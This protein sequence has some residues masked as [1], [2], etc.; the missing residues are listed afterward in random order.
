MATPF[1][2][3]D[4]NAA[5]G[6][7]LETYSNAWVRS[8]STPNGAID[9]AGSAARQQNV[10]TAIYA[11]SN[12]LAPSADYEVSANLVVVSGGGT[13][14]VGIC[15]RMAGTGGAAVT[16][17]QARL[18]NNSSGLVL[19]RFING[20]TITLLS[21]PLN[22]EAGAS[23]KITLRMLGDQLSVLLD[24]V[25]VLGPVTDGNIT[26]P[27]YTGMR[28][29]SANTSQI[30]IDNL[31]S[32]PVEIAQPVQITGS[33]T[34]QSDSI[35]AVVSSEI[36]V[37]AA[38]NEQPESKAIVAVSQVR[39][40]LSWTENNESIYASLSVGDA[41]QD[42]SISAAWTEK[43]DQINASTTVSVS[44]SASWLEQGEVDA[45]LLRVGTAGLASI[46]WSEGSEVLR[47]LAS[48]QGE[49]PEDIDALTVPP[50]Q[51]VVFEGSSRVVAFEGG[52]RVVS[53]EGSKR[54]VEFQ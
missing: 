53:F 4:F 13:P 40:T 10:N 9:V 11:N 5:D 38:W 24:D 48:V 6:V 15:G 2:F 37:S 36:R 21:M 26:A 47:I 27:G 34:E 14:S 33:W 1:F 29:A 7:L 19:A 17:Y 18:V 49:G 35:S 50:R 51:T 23:P 42:V 22:Y 3:D 25:L 12:S 43:N 32:A 28:M 39:G 41:P 31:R 8:T 54:L 30:R 52:K 46:S 20:G 44:A 16:F 45:L